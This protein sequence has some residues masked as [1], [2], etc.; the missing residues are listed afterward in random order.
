[1]KKLLQS[2]FILLFVASSV[3]AQ[4]RT[5]TGTVTS[6]EDGLPIPGVS[7]KVK[8]TNIGASTGANGKFSLNVPASANIIVVSSIGFATQ[9]VAISGTNLSISLSTDSKSLNE[10]VVTGVLGI[11]RQKK[12][13]GYS[14]A[15]VDSK[16]LTAAKAVNVAN[17]L[18]G[19]VSGLNVTTLNNGVF[20]DVKINLRGIRSLT[21][22]NNPMLLLDGVPSALSY[23]SS[24]NPNDIEDVTIL[25]G[26]SAAAIYGP[27]ARNGV[28]VVTTKKGSSAPQVTFGHSSQFSQISFFPALQ[29]KFGSGGYG[30]YTPYENWSWGPAFDGS[31]VEIGHTLPDGSIQKVKYSPTNDREDFFNT[32]YTMQNDLS[33]SAKDL[34]LNVQDALIK[35]VVPDDKNRRTGIRLNTS[36]EYGK[37]KI[38]MNI[39]YINQDYSVFDDNGM[40]SYYSSKNIGGRSGLMPL[41]FNT[42]ANIPLTSYKDFKNDLYSQFNYYFNDYGDNPYFAIDNWRLDGKRY[43]LLSNLE[44]SIKPMEGLN[45]TWRGGFTSRNVDETNTSKGEVPNAYGISRGLDIIS[46]NVYERASYSKRYS[47]ELFANYNKK[48]NDDFKIGAILGTYMRSSSARTTVAGAA[49]LV[50]PELFNPANRTGEPTGTSSISRSRLFSVYGSASLNYKGWANLEFTA[51]NDKTSVLNLDNNS[52]F[53]PGVNASVVL[54]DAI[55]NIRGQA[56]TYLKLRASWNKTGNADIS[57]YS[58]EAV[59]GQ[60]GGFP[61]GSLPGFTAGN[62]TYDAKLKPEFINSTEVGLE[63]GFWDGRINLEATYY[64]SINDNQIIPISVSSATGYTSAYVNA[65]SFINKGFEFDLKLKTNTK[66]A[67]KPRLN[68]NFSYNDSEITQIYDGLDELS[69][70]GFGTMAANYAI[71][72]YPAFVIKA[73][74]YN[75]DPQGRV[76]VDAVSGYPSVNSNLKTF[77]RTLPKYILGINPSFDYKNFSLSMLF[78]YKAGHYAYSEFGRDMAWTGVSEATVANNRERFVIPNSVYLDPVTNTYV[79]NTNVTVA[80]VNDFFTGGNTFQNVGTNFLYSAASWRFRELSLSYRIPGK[81]LTKQGFVKSASVALTGRNLFLWVPSTNKFQDP[82]FN[83]DTGNVAGIATSQINPPV[84]TYGFNLT[85]NF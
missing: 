45:I 52:F 78:E 26:S 38:G 69:I 72:G 60:A 82:D 5:I 76:I 13:I 28:I 11:E 51:R 14:T 44:M 10:I 84:R 29:D 67:F 25:K 21:G 22:N 40:S 17:G 80:D 64:R 15:R 74:D 34:Y 53:Y 32:G 48:L 70:G 27:D 58:L 31:M 49:N 24:L 41:I 42:P 36:K 57:P 54:T 77:G 46:G 71:K 6:S 16:E 59:F 7:V 37:F 55:Q 81:I 85:V 62:T 9:E 1:M 47:S 43:D 18:Q 75:R 2:L 33:F 39:N 12:E 20:E 4:E 63:S 65:A 8:G 83:F 66:A 35:G 56:L 30:S 23:L 68:F 19:K 50:V 79:Q 61:Y 3:M 73:S